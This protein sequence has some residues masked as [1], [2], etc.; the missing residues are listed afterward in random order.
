[1]AVKKR[2]E[3]RIVDPPAALF[4]KLKK[5]ARVNKRTIGKQAEF[6]LENHFK[7]AKAA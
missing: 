5:I 2:T 1:M 6:I 3:I 7:S 4:D